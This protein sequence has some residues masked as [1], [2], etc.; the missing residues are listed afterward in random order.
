M[1]APLTFAVLG[2]VRGWRGDTEIDPGPPKQQA[3][4]ALLLTRAGHPV[5]LHEIVDVLWGAQPPDTA[6]NVVHRHIGALRRLFDPDL[7]VRG[8]SRW[9]IRGAGGYRL[10]IDPH[11]VDLGRFRALR[12]QA[13]HTGEP[14]RA[15]ELLTE[16]LA[17]WQGPVAA[18]LPAEIRTHPA[19]TTVDAELLAAVKAAA[20]TAPAAGPAVA[21]RVLDLTRQ[22]AA[23]HPLDEVLQSRLMLLLAATGHQAEALDVHQRIREALADELGLDPGPELQAAHL[24][25]LQREPATP[26]KPAPAAVRPAQLPAALPVFTGRDEELALLTEIDWATVVTI[27]GMAGV[28]KT[29]LAVHWA[30]RIAGRYPD[31]QLHLDLRGFHPDGAVNPA[32]ALHTL[33]EALGIAPGDVPATLDAR[34]A[35]FRSLLTDRRVL[36]L[37]DNARDSA[38][39][40]PLLPG[41]PGCLTVV[42]SRHQLVDLVAGHGAGTVTLEPLST[43]E[44]TDLLTRRLGAR[45][46]G[47]EPD[48]VAGIVEHCG[49]LPLALAMVSARAAMNPGLPLS[50]IVADLRRHRGGLGAFTGE[51]A[52]SDARSVFDWSYQ[53]LSPAAARLFR[54][55]APHPGPDCSATAAA[56]LAGVPETELRAPL[57]ELLRAHLITEPTVG[58]YGCHDLL[59]AYGTALAAPDTGS[60]QRLHD[61]YLHSA[62]AA[63]ELMFAGRTPFRPAAPDPD[64]APITFADAAAAL[65]WI[66]DELPVLLATTRQ[67]DPESHRYRWQL[68]TVL[69]PH[70]DRTGRWQIQRE[71]Q[72]T[73]VRSAE[74]DDDR[75]GLACAERSLGFA[76][77]RLQ[78][79]PEADEH[80]RRAVALFTEIDDHD[81]LSFTHRLLAFLANQ[82][83]DHRDALQHYRIAADLYTGIGQIRGRATVHN[84]TGWTYILMGDFDQAVGECHAAIDEQRRAGNL[85]GEAAAWD[86]LGY[87]QHHLAAYDDARTSFGH[88]LRLYRVVCDRYLEADTLVHLGD[89]EQAAGHEA[90]AARSWSQALEILDDLGHP[91]AEALRTRTGL[92]Q[93]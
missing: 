17:L 49:R 42:T 31:G 8:T 83:G 79:R 54:L 3:I 92:R 75:H 7:P 88:A 86:S 68:A 74:A 37:L 21:G 40:L 82:R 93:R 70:L 1:S 47:R 50:S 76:E 27:G 39:V 67:D 29:S 23:K 46:T 30:H 38:Q 9:L 22:T 59:R 57:T 90:S 24:R 15:A 81:G 85:N 6:A 16:A 64:A 12:A 2:P 19:F 72:L 55:L 25:V 58:R 62:Y 35:L 73:A 65:A 43:A 71:L 13:G 32:H 56:V 61:H 52:R 26:K 48:A 20:E 60:R 89:T 80:L 33:L 18:G 63:V 4:L 44:A 36:I 66:D 41:A 53:V 5:P 10:D 28:G 87:A 45:R 51:S 11:S 84:E 14:G 69:E 34:S 91:D 78:N 77:G